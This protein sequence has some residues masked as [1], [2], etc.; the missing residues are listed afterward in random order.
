MSDQR[1]PSD[2]NAGTFNPL[3]DSQFADMI[4]DMLHIY[5]MKEMEQHPY[6]QAYN[7]ELLARWGRWHSRGRFFFIH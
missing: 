4:Q 7:V 6:L 2:A 5:S 3:E 1:R